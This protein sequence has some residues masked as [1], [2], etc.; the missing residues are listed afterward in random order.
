M[1]RGK[2]WTKAESIALVEAFVHISEDEIVGVNQRKETLYDRVILEAKQ[3]YGVSWGR[4]LVACRSRW[5]LVS[6]EVSKFIAADLLVQS[7]ERSGWNEDD[8]YNAT[9]KAY[10]STKGKVSIEDDDEEIEAPGNN[11]DPKALYFEFKEEWEILKHHEKWRATLS[12]SEQKRKTSIPHLVDT[13]SSGDVSDI[14]STQRP[15]GS[16]K[17]KTVLAIKNS[18]DSLI[19]EIRE[20]QV[21]NDQ[22]RDKIVSEMM[23]QMKQ[24]A[25]ES[26]QSLKEIVSESTDKITNAMR[27]KLLLEMDWSNMSESFRENAQKRIED[28][29]KDNNSG[30]GN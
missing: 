15:I 22:T 1:P 20:Q 27:I 7:V 29:F 23:T 30:Q 12:K 21:R 13:S 14:A 16:K 8:Y 19:E 3:R 17:A 6:R 24:S 28:F 26:I 5:Q 4:G 18:A 11:D 25:N 10:H 2:S 9:V